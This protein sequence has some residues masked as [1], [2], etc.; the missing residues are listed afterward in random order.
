MMPIEVPLCAA[1]CGKPVKVWPNKQSGKTCG[2]KEC[3]AA[4]AVERSQP[5]RPNWWR[6]KEPPPADL[7]FSDVET[8]DGGI[9]QRLVHGGCADVAG[10]SSSSMKQCIQAPLAGV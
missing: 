6:L 4:L 7:H 9:G 10:H 1:G 8:N 3:M 2:S 5:D